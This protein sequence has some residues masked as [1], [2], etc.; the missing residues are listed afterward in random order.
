MVVEATKEINKS[1]TSWLHWFRPSLSK[2]ARFL[3]CRLVP[4]RRPRSNINTTITI[5]LA[6]P[7][8]LGILTPRRAAL[9]AIDLML[10]RL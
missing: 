7:P 5:P 4:L 2:L 8:C 6:I 9:G 10:T 3:C 1:P